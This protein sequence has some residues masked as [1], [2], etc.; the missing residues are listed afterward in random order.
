QQ[1][2]GRP[3]RQRPERQSADARSERRA[4]ADAVLADHLL[5]RL[6]AARIAAMERRRADGDA[7]VVHARRVVRRLTRLQLD[8]VES[9]SECSRPWLGI[10]GA[11][12]GPDGLEYSS[13]RRGTYHGSVAAVSWP[14]R[15]QHN[16]G[17]ILERI[18]FHPDELQPAV[19]ERRAG[20][21]ELHARPAH[22]RQH[23]VA[24]ADGTGRA[25]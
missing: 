1:P 9:G 7:L 18:R 17:P 14:R 12:P 6:E 16:L 10:S 21:A 2:A 24:D 13:S 8:W 11:E 23:V 5:L 3:V 25:F 20:Y 19:P 15:D 4:D 22:D